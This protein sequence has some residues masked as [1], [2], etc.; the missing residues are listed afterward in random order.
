M[1]L[2]LYALGHGAIE[3]NPLISKN[4][5]NLVIF[6]VIGILLIISVSILCDKLYNS[7]KSILVP[8]YMMGFVVLWN[9]SQIL[10]IS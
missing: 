3:L 1:V 9:I 5:D 6:K 8:I 4:M 10:V 7:K 2:T